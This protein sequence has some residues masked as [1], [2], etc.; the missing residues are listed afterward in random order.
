MR[1]GRCYERRWLVLG[2]SE[3]AGGARISRTRR[4]RTAGVADEGRETS[5]SQKS[6]KR[7]EAADGWTV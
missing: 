7:R 2:S 1:I 3:G 5:R 4:R 6:S